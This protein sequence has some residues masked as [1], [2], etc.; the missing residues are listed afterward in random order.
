MKNKEIEFEKHLSPINAWA[1]AFGSII[2]WGAFVMPGTTFLPNGGPFGTVVGM[3]I[4]GVIMS[5]ISINYGYMVNKFPLAGGEYVFTKKVLGDKHAFICGW[6]LS[7]AYLAIVPLNATALGL[8]SRKLL[9]DTLQFGYLYSVAGYE[10]FLGEIML[11]TI[12]LII[13]AWLSIKGVSVAGNIQSIMTAVL[14]TAVLI[15]LIGVII[16]ED[17]NITNLT[18]MLPDDTSPFKAVGAVVA[19]A[20]WAFIGFDVIPQSAEEFNFSHKKTT[21][22]MFASV[23]FAAFV[24][25]AMTVITGSVA[26][27]QEFLANNYDWTT[28]EAVEVMFG[29][30]GIIALGCAIV[31]A[32][33]TGIIGFYMASSRLIYSIAQDG[34]LPYWFGKLDTKYKTPKNAIVS[35]LC[36]SLIAPWFGREVLQWIVDMSSVGAAIGFGY[37]SIVTF[38]TLKKTNDRNIRVAITS[39]L[40]SVISLIFIMLLFVPGMPGYLGIE[41]RICLSIWIAIGVVFYLLGKRRKLD[42]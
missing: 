16:N 22:L 33:M 35:C 42:K 20:P 4:A 34:V 23:F 38:I 14:M 13:F 24:Y 2:G 19:I 17:A 8:V 36:V 11:A 30:F 31:C 27:W 25:I 28:G 10:I 9:G 3:L 12:T 32:I 5:I 41:A 39:I 15:L 26:P 18:P 1:L 40:G 29:K 37:T 7:L 6:F 21:Q